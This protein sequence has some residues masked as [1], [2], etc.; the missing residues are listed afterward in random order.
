MPSSV[1]AH[2]SDPDHYATSIRGCDT[3][4][5]VK[6]RGPFSAELTKIDLD[7]LWMQQG[8]T[9]ASVLERCAAS[10]V[11]A[12]VFFLT[13]PSEAPMYR[14]GMSRSVTFEARNRHPN[15]RISTPML[16]SPESMYGPLGS[17]F[18]AAR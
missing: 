2:Y 3:T 13:E 11:R 4:V 1:I 15:N 9:S 8:R 18:E 12:I 6:G 14:S 10:P 17:I 7:R 16:T 5:L